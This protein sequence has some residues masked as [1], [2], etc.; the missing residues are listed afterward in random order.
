MKSTKNQ[1]KLTEKEKFILKGLVGFTCQGCGK[2][3]KENKLEIHRIK[4]GID[5]GKYIPSNI[6]ILCKECHKMRDFI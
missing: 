6:Q 3:F 1:L 4:R 2:I 5:G